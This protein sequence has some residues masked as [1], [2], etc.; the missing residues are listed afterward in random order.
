MDQVFASIQTTE[1]KGGVQLVLVHVYTTL[2][3]T[4]LVV[5]DFADEQCM[6]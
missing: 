3:R 4:L 2:S 6:R 1:E 5:C